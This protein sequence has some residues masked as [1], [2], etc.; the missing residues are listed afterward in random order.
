M[1]KKRGGGRSS[2]FWDEKERRWKRCPPPWGRGGKGEEGVDM[3]KRRLGN[4][5]NM[6]LNVNRKGS[7]SPEEKE[8][9][10]KHPRIAGPQ[11]KKGV[12]RLDQ[13]CSDEREKERDRRKKKKKKQ[14]KKE[15]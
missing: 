8:K 9:R 2:T 15:N 10:K 6:H 14:K 1:N 4:G 12:P 7:C 11:K 13:L 5:D 3:G